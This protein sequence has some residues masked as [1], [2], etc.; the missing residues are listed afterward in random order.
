MAKETMSKMAFEEMYSDDSGVEY[1]VRYDCYGKSTEGEGVIQFECIEKIDFPIS[2]I[3]WL[4]DCLEVI[5]HEQG[6]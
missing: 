4:I 3:N 1:A 6:F 5:R 2:K